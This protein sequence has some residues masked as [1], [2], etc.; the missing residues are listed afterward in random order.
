MIACIDTYYADDRTRTGLVLF[1]N[2]TDRQ[3]AREVVQERLQRPLEYI[4]GHFFQRELPCI[5]DI[6]HPF[7]D[8]VETVIID[9]YV[10]L[11][12][13]GRKGLGAFLYEATNQSIN[14]IGVAKSRFQGSVGTEV[15]R[16]TSNNPLIVTS[17]G[18]DD[19][20]AAQLIQSM[21]GPHRIPTL[22]KRADYLSRHGI[23]NQD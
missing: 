18:L 15:F 19:A 13:A 5:L 1:E 2:W 6:T 23:S 8:V 14:V 9:G 22:I 20:E 11:N 4:P 10:W 16:G 7:I 3:A 21:H 17:A 12:S